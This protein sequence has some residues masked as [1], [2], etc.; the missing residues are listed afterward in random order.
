MFELSLNSGA[1]DRHF[2]LTRKEGYEA[3]LSY[4]TVDEGPVVEVINVKTSPVRGFVP[5]EIDYLAVVADLIGACL[6]TRDR[7]RDVPVD[8]PPDGR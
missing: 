1:A 8:P 6:K 7:A 4:P 5:N 2:A 3:M